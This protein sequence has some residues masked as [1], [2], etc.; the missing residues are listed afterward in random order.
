MAT[1]SSGAPLA[2]GEILADPSYFYFCLD[3]DEFLDF[4]D[5]FIKE[6]RREWD[7]TFADEI[8]SLPCYFRAKARWLERK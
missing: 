5:E 1:L 2:W 7:R 8:D 3:D 6:L 4:R